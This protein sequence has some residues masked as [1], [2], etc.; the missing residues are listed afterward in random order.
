MKT[1]KYHPSLKII[2]KAMSDLKGAGIIRTKNLVGDLGEY[3]CKVLLDIELHGSPV[4]QGFDGYDSQRN[5][6]EIKTRRTPKSQAKV[7]FRSFSFKYCLYVELTEF[8][9]V[10]KILRIEKKN[11]LN[12][13]DG[14]GDRLS[15]SKLN[16]S[17]P[18]IL[19]LKK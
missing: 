1:I 8:Y 18:K 2:A 5:R 17:N 15:I 9:E 10:A 16:K 13:L 19:Y 14:I 6:V 4:E 3:Y 11:L 12:Q 7:I